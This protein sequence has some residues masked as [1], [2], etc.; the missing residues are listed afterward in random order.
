METCFPGRLRSLASEIVDSSLALLFPHFARE[1]L[2]VHEELELLGRNLDEAHRL[3]DSEQGA[4]SYVE[5]LPIVREKLLEDA[6][7]IERTDPAA[8]SLHEVIL[9]YPGFFATAV[10]R[11][12]HMLF[13]QGSSLLA[14]VM[15]ECAHSRTGIDIHPGARI[16]S[17]FVIDHGTGLVV[18][19]TSVIGNDVKLYQGVTLGALVVDKELSFRKRH[20][21][22]E[23]RVVV[24]ANATILGGLTVVGTG[25]IVGGNVWLTH[26]VPAGAIVTHE[27]EIRVRAPGEEIPLDFQI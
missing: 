1:P 27:P 19:E 6:S 5:C 20:P 24:Y 4:R 2:G 23:D 22:L 11:M 16:G 7:A 15:A 9:C 13:G 10:Y 8:R 14:R 26:S 25:S 3:L 21:T 18:G 17:R 12:A